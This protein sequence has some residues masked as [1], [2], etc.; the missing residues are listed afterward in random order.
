[1]A[2]ASWNLVL[3]LQ[4]EFCSC[5]PFLVAYLQHLLI[6]NRLNILFIITLPPPVA[7]LFLIVLIFTTLIFHADYVLQLELSFFCITVR[8]F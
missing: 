1:M 2:F 6:R 7:F 5:I 3:Q 4:C 8:Y